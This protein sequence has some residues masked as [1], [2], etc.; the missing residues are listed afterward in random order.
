MS[1]TVEDIRTPAWR[2]IKAW[3]DAELLM[4]RADLEKDL[5]P[6][7]TAKIRGQIRSLNLLLALAAPAPTVVVEEE[8]D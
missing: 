7:K 2:K 3:A 5:L 8:T 4:L 6:E 1:L